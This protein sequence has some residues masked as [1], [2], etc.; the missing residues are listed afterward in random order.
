MARESAFRASRDR[1]IATTLVNARLKKRSDGRRRH[2]RSH[3]ARIWKRLLFGV[4]VTPLTC[5]SN[6]PY[7]SSH[8]GVSCAL[9]KID[10]NRAQFP[11]ILSKRGSGGWGRAD[12]APRSAPS[13]CPSL[14]PRDVRRR[15]ARDRSIHARSRDHPERLARRM[16][17]AR[18]EERK[19]WE[20]ELGR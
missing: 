7:R 5:S 11:A 8:P 12:F 18:G 13:P 16:L 10:V 17:D 1:G 9:S 6:F 19:G 15:T 4:I 20:R 2:V 14:F 3:T